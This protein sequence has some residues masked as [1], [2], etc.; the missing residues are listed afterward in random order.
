MPKCLHLSSSSPQTA[1]TFFFEDNRYD[2]AFYVAEKW[3]T[4]KTEVGGHLVTVEQAA[5]YGVYEFEMRIPSNKILDLTVGLN[6]D[7]VAK[8]NIVIE[9]A[10][11]DSKAKSGTGL[12]LPQDN[13]FAKSKHWKADAIR[14]GYWAI[15]YNSY[16]TNAHTYNHA[17]Q[18][19]A[20]ELRLGNRYTAYAVFGE[21]TNSIVTKCKDGHFDKFV[22]G[23]NNGRSDCAKC[24]D[25]M[26]KI[27]WLPKEFTDEYRYG[28]CN[29]DCRQVDR[30]TA[31]TKALD[32]M[33]AECYAVGK[34]PA[35]VMEVLRAGTSSI[36][37]RRVNGH[38]QRQSQLDHYKGNSPISRRDAKQE[39]NDNDSLY[40]HKKKYC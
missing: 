36:N 4:A 29:G 12:T 23:G 20:T 34:L 10:V 24:F 8:E 27:L 33:A 1:S 39:D 25:S 9:R 6:A 16:H 17:K 30:E 14:D 32:V 5:E 35:D 26:Q 18:A 15:K 37:K 28:L 40:K 21:C 3:I 22:P 2:A 13:V 11:A 31:K 7:I 19:Q 38:Y